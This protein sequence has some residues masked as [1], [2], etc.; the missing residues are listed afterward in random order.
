MAAYVSLVP[1]VK[2]YKVDQ[3]A[4][5]GILVGYSSITKGYRVYRPSTGKEIVNRN[6]KFNELAGWDWNKSEEK[7]AKITSM[8]P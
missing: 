3:K 2:R 6:V 1:K 4:K 7:P 8:D 5:I